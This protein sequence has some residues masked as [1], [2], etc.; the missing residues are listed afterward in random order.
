MKINSE[1]L[2]LLAVVAQMLITGTAGEGGSH[3]NEDVLTRLQT[4]SAGEGEGSAA[5]WQLN[6]LKKAQAIYEGEQQ[7]EQLQQY[8]EVA[9]RERHAEQQRAEG[10]SLETKQLFHAITTASDVDLG[11]LQAMLRGGISV[12]D[13]VNR[14]GESPLHAAC[15]R[16]QA[17][18]VTLLLTA[19]ADPNA[20]ANRAVSAQDMT[21]L[22]WCVH[23][24]H[25][26][27]TEA[28]LDSPKTEVNMHFVVRQRGGGEGNNPPV[29]AM[30][31]AM[32]R[33]DEDMIALLQEYKAKSYQALQSQSQAM[34]EATAA[35][36]SVLD[37]EEEAA[38]QRFLNMEA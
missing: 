12:R 38:F 13:R 35:A 29:T 15:V 2:L 32:S 6:R 5:D 31:L 36:D 8:R 28:L 23:A 30:D 10:N 4:D 20:R 34:H 19:G 11:A 21:P 3:S 25:F 22:S 14:N 26:D 1:L 9:V 24:G 33:R 17:A 7:Q 16:G 18:V 27:A 37:D